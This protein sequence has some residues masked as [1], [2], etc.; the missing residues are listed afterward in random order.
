MATT[1]K[2]KTRKQRTP[3]QIVADLEAEITRVK[4]RAASKAVKSAPEGKAFLAAVRA[5]DKAIGAAAEAGHP[6]M[7]AALEAAR[8]TLGDQ[9]ERMGVAAPKTRRGWT[10]GDAA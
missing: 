8:T 2:K 3:D 6:E 10:K 5:V 4:E 1:T 9:L 7:R